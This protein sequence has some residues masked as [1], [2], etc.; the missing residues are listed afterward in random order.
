MLKEII[1]L[2]ASTANLALRQVN[3]AMINE[4]E[5][6]ICAS[7]PL[8]TAKVEC[9]SNTQSATEFSLLE[10]LKPGSRWSRLAATESTAKQMTAHCNVDAI[11]IRQLKVKHMSTACVLLLDPETVSR[12]TAFIANHGNHAITLL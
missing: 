8:K 4:Y 11:C 12:V 9:N 7:G 2:A 1:K 6:N 10:Y 3:L 5:E